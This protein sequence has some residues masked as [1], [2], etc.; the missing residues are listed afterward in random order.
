M[1]HIESTFKKFNNYPEDITNQLNHEVKLKRTKNMN[2]E[3]S[4]ITQTALNDQQKRHLLVLL[5]AGN[6]GET[7]L[8]SINKFSSRVLPCNV[9]TYVIYSRIKLGSRF[10]IK[11]HTKKD[12]QHDVVY[13]VQCP[14]KQC[15]EDYTGGTGRSLIERVKGHSGKDLKSQLFKHS[16]ET[17]HKM[18]T[19]HD[20]KIIGKG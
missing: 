14:E 1:K 17:R 5:Y 19:L 20:F 6:N 18:V 7:I 2:I 9:K 15:T 12:H 8:K 10:Q 4:T 3:R 13:Y 16:M 11:D